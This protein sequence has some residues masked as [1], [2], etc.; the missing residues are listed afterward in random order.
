VR[1]ILTIAHLTLE[2]A[3]RR[4][5]AAAAVLCGAAFLAVFATAVFFGHSGMVANDRLTF[6]ARQAFLTML[7]LGGLYASNFL[8]V[9]F[10]VLLPVDTLS[11]EIDSGVM[12]TLAAK[13]VRRAEILIGKWLG[14]GV[15]VV[16]Y[17]LLMS[18]GVVAAMWM[19]T[20]YVPVN[21]WIGL[22]LMALQA[23][24]LMTVSIAGGTRFTTITN[25][26]LALGF[27]G[28]AF[29]GGWIE[30][31]GA[32]GGVEEV[33]TVG[34]VASL[35]SPTDALWRLASYHLQPPIVRD[36]APLIF[37]VAA[38]PT[39]LMVWWAA[40]FTLAVLAWSVRSFERRAL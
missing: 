33:R 22:P 11:G 28:I 15:M 9:L 34:V 30:Q 14:H 39:P 1:N 3:R 20:G 6:V 12:Q 37:T 26:V 31:V 36:V 8:S 21:L 35:I 10:A 24:L 2:E 13:P 5:V 17:L 38:A 16:A 4:R 25:G 27:Y 32:L 7:T 40:A 18:L 23:I 19:V 29:V